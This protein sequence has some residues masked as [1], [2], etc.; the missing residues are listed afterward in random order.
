[1]LLYRAEVCPSL[2]LVLT[3]NLT[4]KPH[5]LY[6]EIYRGKVYQCFFNYIIY[7]QSVRLS[8]MLGTLFT[9][10]L[11]HMKRRVVECFFFLSKQTDASDISTVLSQ[12]KGN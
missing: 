8:A 2:N 9:S 1:M 3:R 5:L 6:F 10:S 4:E 7:L 11:E 12:Y